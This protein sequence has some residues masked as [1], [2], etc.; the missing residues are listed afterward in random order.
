MPVCQKC[1][2]TG[3]LKLFHNA[4]MKETGSQKMLL[5]LPVKV[6]TVRPNDCIKAASHGNGKPFK[7]IGC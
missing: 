3:I 6:I 1:S 7:Y 4:F 2:T 5:V